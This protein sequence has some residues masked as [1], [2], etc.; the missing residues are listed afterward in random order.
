MYTFF[1]LSIISICEIYDFANF[2]LII[3]IC[4]FVQW[5]GCVNKPFYQRQGFKSLR[6]TGQYTSMNIWLSLPKTILQS[7]LCPYLPDCKKPITAIVYYLYARYTL[8]I[9]CFYMAFT[10]ATGPALLTDVLEQHQALHT[11]DNTGI[12]R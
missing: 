6:S 8:F 3:Y 4:S 5:M 10:L 12:D 2:K 9:F 1:L 7:C 11:D